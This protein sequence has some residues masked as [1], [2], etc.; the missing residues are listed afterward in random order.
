M[1]GEGRGGEEVRS[2]SFLGSKLLPV[3]V[4]A[5]ARTFPL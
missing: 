4:H 3:C 2:D 5:H 1:E